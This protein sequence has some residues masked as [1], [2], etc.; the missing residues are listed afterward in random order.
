MSDASGDDSLF[1]DN[2]DEEYEHG[3]DAMCHAAR[4]IG[5]E[6]IHRVYGAAAAAIDDAAATDYS[7][8]LSGFMA[9][10]ILTALRAIRDQEA[11]SADT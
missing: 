4:N 6:M 5:Q 9:L 8:L 10:G 3:L 11:G 2:I 1:F 7:R